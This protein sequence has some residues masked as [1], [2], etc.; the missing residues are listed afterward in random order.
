MV[1][2]IKDAD[3]T[4]DTPVVYGQQER[5]LYGREV[6]FRPVFR[7]NGRL[8]QIRKPICPGFCRWKT[9]T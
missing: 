9:M 4:K 5:P 2:F 3:C 7:E 6:R 8:P 1:N